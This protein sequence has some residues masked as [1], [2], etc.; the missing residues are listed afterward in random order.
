MT[1]HLQ[2]CARLKIPSLIWGSL[3]SL[4]LLLL[5]SCSSPFANDAPAVIL[6]SIRPNIQVHQQ[7]EIEYADVTLDGRLLFPVTESVSSEK[8]ETDQSALRLRVGSIE[9]NL[10]R[11]LNKQIDPD[12]LY[13]GVASL[14]RQTVILAGTQSHSTQEIL[15]TVTELDA[16]LAQQ[17]IPAL[18]Q[19]WADIIH[20][21]LRRAW[22]V[23]SPAARQQQVL[24]FAGT[25]SA[26]VAISLGLSAVQRWSYRLFKRHK[27]QIH[28]HLPVDD[29]PDRLANPDADAAEI[30]RDFEQTFALKQR[31][32]INI[33]RRVLWFAQL[34]IWV[35][36]S[37]WLLLIF[38]ETYIW[39]RALIAFTLRLTIIVFLMLLVAQICRFLLNRWLE[40]WVE[41]ASLEPNEVQRIA[42]R[43]R[44][45]TGVLGGI[46]SIAVL[47]IG[48]VLL[49]DLQQT[50][51]QS[52]LTSVGLLGVAIGLVFQNL[53]RD[54]VNGL[55]IIFGDQYAVGD[56]VNIAGVDGLV[57]SMSLR[58]TNIRGPRGSLN[59][60]PHGQ[61][62]TVQNLTKDWSRADLTVQIA[63]DTDVAHAMQVMQQVADEM[64]HDPDWQ[65][66]ILEPTNRL[67]VSQISATGTQILMWIKTTRAD[68]WEVEREFRYRLKLAFDKEGIHLS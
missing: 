63:K 10:D 46:I 11:V 21:A 24:Q 28:T 30:V 54:W 41:A 51:I 40:S 58:S 44:T 32:R 4:C 62:T 33:W 57:E 29:V 47:I 59:T 6:P 5:T 22:A 64:A 61:I 38:P 49:A 35:Y 34:A 12:K 20:Q 56:T 43:A 19:N 48:I 7:G 3:V 13:V 39:G 27:E 68:N 42:L 60:V 26:I 67:G 18:A 9:S 36:G 14:G 66:R 23:R 16:Q 1:R 45:L 53:F 15:L 55:F 37:A 52:I 25:L 8:R 31:Q 17:T 65:S 2:T 50:P